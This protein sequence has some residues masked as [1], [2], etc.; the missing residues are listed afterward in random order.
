MRRF[1]VFGR[2]EA[3]VA[4]VLWI[5]HTYA[6][7]IAE[8]TPYLAVTSPE[9]GS[10]KTRLLECVGLLA[11]SRPPIFIIPTAST[12]YRMLEADPEA[13]LLLDELDAVFHDRTDKYEEVRSI[14]NAGHRRGATVPRTVSVGNKH[15]V[16][17]FPVFG[18]KVLAGIGQLPD[19]VVDRSIPIRM[20]KRKRSEP[21]EKFRAVAAGREAKPVAGAL[22][23]AVVPQPSALSPT[24]PMSYPIAPPMP[25]SRCSP[26][27]TLPVRAGRVGLARL[28]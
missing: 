18:P 4:V 20:L 12:I 11:R 1:V 9:K 3:V 27:L 2:P 28:P 8:A 24:C 6:I 23:A 13:P 16:Q 10:G 22:A 21:V 25:G 7:G 15:A 17:F 14:I 19:T 5:A 26:W